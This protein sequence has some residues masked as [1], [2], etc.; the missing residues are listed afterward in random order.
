MTVPG[1]W[2]APASWVLDEPTAWLDVRA[3]AEFFDRLLLALRAVH[4]QASYGDVVMVAALIQRTQQQMALVS[5]AVSQL[6]T[7]SR[8]AQYLFWLED[9]HR[10]VRQVVPSPRP[11]PEVLDRG[12][13]FSGVTFTY[14]GTRASSK[15]GPSG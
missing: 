6:V 1:A 3:G 15:T 12:L 14:P 11:V 7:N 4:G 8:A 5:S 13:Q 2:S 10:T 9:H